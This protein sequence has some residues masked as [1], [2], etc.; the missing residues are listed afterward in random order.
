MS[1]RR[2]GR[3]ARP[4]SARRRGREAGDR[5]AS[6]SAASPVP[7]EV[8]TGGGHIIALEDSQLIKQDM[9]RNGTLSFLVIIG[10]YYF[11]YRRFGAIMYSSVP[12]VVGQFL[13]LAVAFLFLRHLNSATTGFWA[14]LMGLGTDFT[15]V[16]Y[17]RYVEERQAGKTLPEALRLMMGVSAFGVF[18]GAITSA[19]TFYAMCVTEY[20][21]LRDFGFLVGTGIMLCMVAILFL[22]PAMIAWNDGRKRKSDVTRRLYLHSFGLERIMT[23][24]TRHPGPVLVV[25]LIVTAGACVAAWNVEFSDSVQ[26]LRSAKNRGILIQEKIG[27]EFGASFNPMMVVARGPDEQTMMGRNRAANR[28]LDRF[29]ADKTLLGYESIFS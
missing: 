19:G 1:G 27:R 9:V 5:P 11:C 10:L 13:T 6:G 24:S 28:I 3:P 17:A 12:L 25:S 2:R 4:S 16:M 23:W 20:K 18:T 22:L 7:P 21:G 14:M 29:V 8:A 15:I 26:D